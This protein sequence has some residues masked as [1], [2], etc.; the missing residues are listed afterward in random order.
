[1]RYDSL[2]HGVAPT[3][4]CSRSTRVLRMFQTLAG[5]LEFQ[6]LLVK[7]L[8]AIDEAKSLMFEEM[9]LQE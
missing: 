5:E 4:L 8:P 7:E 3:Q 9:N 6:L 2:K 1:M